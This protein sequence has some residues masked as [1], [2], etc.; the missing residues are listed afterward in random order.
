MS[1][2]GGQTR[3]VKKQAEVAAEKKKKVD[4]SVEHLQG[5]KKTLRRSRFDRVDLTSGAVHTADSF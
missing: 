4:L 3:S 1:L 5:L 2:T